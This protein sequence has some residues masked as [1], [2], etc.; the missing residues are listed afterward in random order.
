MF[1]L[2]LLFYSISFTISSPPSLFKTFIYVL[3]YLP[4]L[5]YSISIFTMPR[6]LLYIRCCNLSWVSRS[7]LGYTLSFLCTPLCMYAFSQYFYILLHF[8]LVFLYPPSPL[9]HC[10]VSCF[11][12]IYV[13]PSP[14]PPPS[15]TSHPS[16]IRY[17]RRPQCTAPWNTW[18]CI[19]KQMH[20]LG[21]VGSVVRVKPCIET[22]D[23][24]HREGFGV[25]S[26]LFYF[27]VVVL[28]VFWVFKGIFLWSYLRVIWLG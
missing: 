17:S 15:C 20:S 12:H 6:L 26:L 18:A 10:S 2:P 7:V 8:L 11:T 5:L 16:F 1:Y 13:S 24:I 9:V 27:D 21:S 25:L 28:G 14:K 19:T 3:F 23:C 22:W 4:L